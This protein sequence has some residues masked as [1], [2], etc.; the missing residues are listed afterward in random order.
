MQGVQYLNITLTLG[1]G[2]KKYVV[3]VKRI[4]P[5]NFCTCPIYLGTSLDYHPSLSLCGLWIYTRLQI[6]NIFSS[7]ISMIN[8]AI[9]VHMYAFICRDMGLVGWGRYSCLIY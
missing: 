2:S 9:C 8:L 4:S 3:Y 1:Q 6:N 7:V 5:F